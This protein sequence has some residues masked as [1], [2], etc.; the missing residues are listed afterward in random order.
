[1]GVYEQI[2]ESFFR[3]PATR[4][5]FVLATNTHGA[6]LKGWFDVVHAARGQIHYAV[7]PDPLGRDQEMDKVLRPEYTTNSSS[8]APMPSTQHPLSS[9]HRTVSL[10]DTLSPRLSTKL[11]TVHQLHH[12]LIL[13]LITN[14]CINPLTALK[15]C[16]NGD[17][18][19]DNDALKTIREICEEAGEVLRR[20]TAEDEEEMIMLAQSG[21][22]LPLANLL[23]LV[24]TPSAKELEAEVL[25]VAR[26]TAENYSSMLQDVRKGKPTE[27]EYLNGHLTRLAQLYGVV[28]P[29]N[30]ALAER[31]RQ[32]STQTMQE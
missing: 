1:M 19:H 29:A 18:L 9:L 12:R 10:L 23:S 32:K 27:I 20:K 14:C 2:V 4:P 26:L 21:S 6:S 3:D 28:T 13:K 22:E 31:L 15:D 5:Q 8:A 24:R 7:V 17:L 16:K 25:R 11:E 30:D